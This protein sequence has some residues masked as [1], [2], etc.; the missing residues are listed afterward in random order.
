M[1][2]HRQQL[3]V[4]FDF[5]VIFTRDVFGLKNSALADALEPLSEG[6]CLRAA[7]FVDSGVV[8]AR[9]QIERRISDYCAACGIELVESPVVVSG[10][11]TAKNDFAFVEKTIR[12]LLALRLDR[13]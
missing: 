12:R 13:H 3:H 11:E 4:A 7:A 5:P 6:R 8:G 9:P 2:A 10:G 1:T